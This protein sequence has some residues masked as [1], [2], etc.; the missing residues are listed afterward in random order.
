MKFS[1]PYKPQSDQQYYAFISYRREGLDKKWAKLIYKQL[2]NYNL[3]VYFK[4]ID[5]S[6]VK[7][8]KINADDK[9]I[10]PIFKDTEQLTAGGELADK[11][12]HALEHSRKLIVVCS[13][14]MKEH[15]Y[16]I[17]LEVKYFR[18]LGHGP[19]DILPVIIE[20]Q[21]ENS[22]P[23]KCFPTDLPLNWHAINI[24]DHKLTAEDGYLARL[25][26]SIGNNK[27]RKTILS[28]IPNLFPTVRRSLEELWEID[29]RQKITKWLLITIFIIIFISILSI[30][31]ILL[32][33]TRTRAYEGISIRLVEEAK[34]ECDKKNM[35]KAALLL[36]YVKECKNKKFIGRFSPFAENLIAKGLNDFYNAADTTREYVT[37]SHILTQSKNKK[38]LASFIPYEN[39]IYL[40]DI[41]NLAIIDTIKVESNIEHMSV[42]DTGKY[43]LVLGVN[44]CTV[45]NLQKKKVCFKKNISL[46]QGYRFNFSPF[47]STIY[48]YCF[49]KDENF[50]HYLS[51]EFYTIDLSSGKETKIPFNFDQAH[52]LLF[53]KMANE[54]KIIFADSKSVAIINL[55]NNHVVPLTSVNG[56]MIMKAELFAKFL[57]I[58]QQNDSGT[59]KNKKYDINIIDIKEDKVIHHYEK[60]IEYKR[61]EKTP[62][63]IANN[64]NVC[65][66]KN[67]L[68]IADS[69]MIH[70]YNIETNSTKT[71]IRDSHCNIYN[72]NQFDTE[73]FGIW[74]KHGLHFY[75]IK[76]GTKTD[77][78]KMSAIDDG[79]PLF[80]R[81]F[82]NHKYVFHTSHNKGT[83]VFHKNIIKNTICK[84][85]GLTGIAYND[86]KKHLMLVY[87]FKH[88]KIVDAEN[89]SIMKEFESPIFVE[90]SPQIIQGRDEFVIRCQTDFA[91][92]NPSEDFLWLQPEWATYSKKYNKITIN[93]DTWGPRTHFYEHDSCINSAKTT[94]NYPLLIPDNNN[95]IVINNSLIN[96]KKRTSTP[97]IGEKIDDS[98]FSFI[99]KSNFY[100]FINNITRDTFN[101]RLDIKGTNPQFSVNMSDNLLF[102]VDYHQN[103]WKNYLYNFSGKL[104]NTYDYI[105]PNVCS[106]DG[107][108]LVG[109]LTKHGLFV[110]KL[111]EPTKRINNIDAFAGILYTPDK[112]NI[113]LSG[114][115]GKNYLISSTF[116]SNIQKLPIFGSIYNDD[117]KELKFSNNNQYIFWRMFH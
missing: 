24:L 79:M 96:I 39:T 43:I 70:F 13:R 41:N 45:L 46:G 37:T 107:G 6:I 102:V 48:P 109:D 90:G 27:Y 103:S 72:I 86:T 25:I 42:S 116:D 84:L 9:T 36:Q 17:N 76:D 113:F 88:I 82:M 56:K 55:E 10:K 60:N 87:N 35:Q 32:Y 99:K 40:W 52:P 73:Q 83:V 93:T 115:S 15:E 78:I 85:K 33:N 112:K 104:L 91:I 53:T 97:I 50:L 117:I 8:E 20:P 11:I 69:S 59:E 114:T 111:N 2:T 34:F 58:V 68:A 92:Y 80:D 7:Q 26:M 29:K 4:D 31:S 106:I 54:N 44:D 22:T 28:L 66:I 47:T 19:K 18:S 3:N 5:D 98:S 62:L 71:I 57:Y 101:I 23:E 12:K 108:F 49:S 94:M 81:F 105:K 14:N 65:W 64:F 77:C 1:K 38:V 63:E 51:N 110:L 61:G 16:W 95:C 67:Q 100:T 75:N 89:N 21:L 74:D 30:L